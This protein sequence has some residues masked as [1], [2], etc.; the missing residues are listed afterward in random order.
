MKLINDLYLNAFMMLKDQS[1]AL[2]FF[3]SN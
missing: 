1:L 3:L 2:V